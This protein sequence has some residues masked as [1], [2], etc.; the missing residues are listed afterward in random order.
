MKRRSLVG[1]GL[2]SDALTLEIAG[3]PGDSTVRVSGRAI[4]DTSPRLRALLLEL[5]RKCASPVVV[6]D[7]SGVTYLD[8]SGV[9]TLLEAAQVARSREVRLRVTGLAGEPKLL[10]QV[11]ELDRIF[12]ALGS[13]VE[14]R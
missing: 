10:V 13:E 2:H 1:D 4:I 12:E 8:T 3:G 6:V 11:T 7:F 14:F 9:A 5:L